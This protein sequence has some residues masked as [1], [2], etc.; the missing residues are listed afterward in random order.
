MIWHDMFMSQQI[1]LAAQLS[2]KRTAGVAF[3]FSADPDSWRYLIISAMVGFVIYP[4]LKGAFVDAQ[5]L[6]K[7]PTEK[8]YQWVAWFY[9]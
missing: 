5:V 9:V 3:S 2:Q 1:L 4:M 6:G 8:Q 7:K